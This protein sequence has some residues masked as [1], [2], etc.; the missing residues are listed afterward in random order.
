MAAPLVA[1]TGTPG[2]GKTTATTELDHPVLHAN[3]LVDAEDL[4]TDRDPDRDS[5]I[6]DLDAFRDAAA[7]RAADADGPLVVESHLSHH[8]DADRVVVLRC[9]P[10][11]VERRR[12]DR[13]ES[14]ESAR[15][16]ADSE[17]LDVILSAAVERHGEG[18]IHELDVTDRDPAAVAARIEAV[19]AGE[20]DPSVGA[21]DWP[22][23]GPEGKP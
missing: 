11:V 18:A 1:V 7:A 14:P 4:W 20:R 13:G 2:T 17:A 15:E 12:L 8:L 10:P 21:V 22:L 6:V 19:V 3:D 23:P 16:N 5:R 9:R